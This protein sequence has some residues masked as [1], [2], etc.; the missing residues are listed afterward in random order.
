MTTESFSIPIEDAPVDSVEALLQRPEGPDGA[1]AVLLAHGSGASVESEF[2]ERFAEALAREGFPVL[3]FRYA[4]AERAA[5]EGKRRPPDRMPL[6]QRV[7]RAALEALEERLPDAP[8][9]LAGKSMGGRVASHLVAEGVPC[10]G[11]ALLGYPLHPTGKP[12]SLRSEHFP[13]VHAP[14]LFLQ[15]TR[16]KLCD[17]ALLERELAKY[18]APYV[19]H[20]VE[21]GDHSF[22]VLKR[23]GRTADEVRAEMIETFASWARAL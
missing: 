12:E 10:A 9:I 8:V 13:R 11:L 14:S 16:D 19:L 6:L 18:G 20:V 4:Y 22:G 3:R 2:L 5:R 17:L 15:G 7:H 21:G 23:S 1:P